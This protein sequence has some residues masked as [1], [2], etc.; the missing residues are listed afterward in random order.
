MSICL[1]IH[2]RLGLC[3]LAPLLQSLWVIFPHTFPLWT[4]RSKNPASTAVHPYLS[5]EEC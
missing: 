2:P 1:S 3:S 5:L 4:L